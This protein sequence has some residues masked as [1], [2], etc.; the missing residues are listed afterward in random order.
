[1]SQPKDYPDQ[2]DPNY[3]PQYRG[4]HGG[5]ANAEA[6]GG[7]NKSSLKWIAGIVATIVGGII[8]IQLQF[9]GS[10]VLQQG[11]AIARIE[12][13]MIYIQNTNRD[14]VV[15][16]AEFR[17]EIEQRISRIE[18]GEVSRSPRER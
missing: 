11:K 15:Q 8:I 4:Y 5:Y 12:E 3:R 2:T 10:E 6:G 13:R 1:M 7:G 14:L 17:R 18:R 9:F 16:Y